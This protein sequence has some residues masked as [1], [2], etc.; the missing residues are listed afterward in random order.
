MESPEPIAIV[1]AA[2]RLPGGV[3]D[4]ASLWQ[5]LSRG[6]DAIGE[7]P[8]DRWNAARFYHP[9]AAAP[10]RMVSRWGG[11]VSN[12]DQFD[13]AFFGIAPREASHMDPQHRWLAEVAWEAIEDAGLPP[14]RLA[15]SRT[16]V[17]V[18]ISSTDFPMLHNRDPRA[19]DGYSNIGST[20]SIAANRLSYLFNF[21]GPSLSVDTACSSSLVALHLATG[22]IWSGE[23]DH[24]IVGGANALLSPESSISFSQAHMLSPRGRCRAFD[25]T[26]DGY[27][28]AEG[29]AA[30]LL[31]PLRIAQKLGLYPRALIIA[32]AS[33]QD[34]HSS[35]LTVPNQQAQEE[36]LREAL[37]RAGAEPHDVVYVEAHGTGTPVGDPIEAH[38]LAEVFGTNRA[39]NDPLFIGSVKTNVGHLESASGLAGLLKAVLV[40]EQ[41]SI[42]PNLHFET[43][44]PLLP[45]DKI[46]VPTALTPL[47]NG[48]GRGP[49][50]AV[51]SFGFGGANAHALLAAA[52]DHTSVPHDKPRDD[53]PCLFPLSARSPGA[54]ADYAEAYAAMLPDEETAPAFT[55][56]EFSA[57]AALGKSHHP[58]R[59]SLVAD[60]LAHLRTQLLQV[61]QSASQPAPAAARPKIAFVFCGQGP[62]WWAMGRQLYERDPIVREMWERCDAV[63][64]KLGGPKLLEALLATEEDSPFARTDFTQ[65]ALFAL[66]AGLVERWRAWGIEA[67]AN[68]G[69]SVGEAAAAWASGIFD[70]E[71]IFHVILTRSHWQAK[72]HG[73]GRMLAAGVSA[74]EAEP[75]VQRFAGRVSIAA[76]NAPRQ[77]T[78]SGETDALEEI[79]AALE[80]EGKFQRFLPTA[81]AFHSAQ[82]DPIESG[83]RD[84]LAGI[85]GHA[86]RVPMISTML[87]QSVRGSE[88]DAEYWWRNVRQP[89]RFAAGIERLLRDEGCT[90]FVE[91]GPHPVMA[92]ALAEITLAQKSSAVSVA[93]LRRGDD[94]TATLLQNLGLL[95]RRGAP[96]RWDALYEQPA[97]PL[98]LPAYPWQRQRLWHESAD[99]ARLLRSAP[100]H[101]LLGD[102]Q[103]LPQ[104]TWLN[105]L[106]TRLLPWLA[107]HR[108]AG[109]A[110]LPGT[111]YL[112][113]AAAAVR[114]HL[115]EPTILLEDIRFHRMLFLPPEQPVPTCVRLDPTA[116]TFQI[117]AAPPDSPAMWEVHAEG[118]YRPGRLRAPAPVDLPAIQHALKEERAPEDLYRKLRDIGQVLGPI[119][120][121]LTSL[122]VAEDE[123]LGRVESHGERTPDDYLSYPPFLDSCFQE[124]ATLEHNLAKDSRGVV[125]TVRQ[126]QLFQPLPLEAFSHLRITKRGQRFFTADVNIY[127]ASGAV[128]A[129]VDGLGV[130]AID[131]LSVQ[132]KSERKFH[133]LAWEEA[134]LVAAPERLTAPVLIFA[135]AQGFG[136]ELED[137]LRA[138]GISVTLVFAQ[139]K[140]HGRNGN[141]L[142]VDLRRADW[143][144]RLWEDLA[145]R[146]PV[147]TR[148]IDLW[149][150]EQDRGCAA[151]LAIA[152]ARLASDERD[153]AARWL[154]VTR[155]AQSVHENEK[156]NPMLAPLWGFTRTIQT[157]H[158]H[159]RVSL[160]DR[161]EEPAA[162]A[163][164]CELEAAE[165]EPEVALRDGVRWVRRLRRVEAKSAPTSTP[166][167]AYA[168]RIGQLGR[169]DS[170]EYRGRAR[171]APGRG[172]VEVEIAAAGLNFRDLMKV[173]GIYPLKDDEPT[174]LG[175]EFGGRI[176]RV[177]SGVKKFKPGDRVMGSARSE[178]AFGSHL[179][180]P[181]DYVWHLPAH[182][183][184][185]EGA[186]IPVV[187]GT[188]YHAL[189]TLARL[190]RGETILIHAAA[191]GVGLAAVQLAHQIGATVLAT[192]GNDEKR[193]LLRSMG[194]AHVM[195]SRT[196][197][198]AD[199]TLRFTEGRG[200]DVVLN[201]LAG[202][203]QQKSLAICAPHG[204][205]VEIGKRDLFENR[206]L[207]LAAFQRSLAFFAFDLPSVMSSRSAEKRALLRFLGSGF[208]RGELQPLPL[209]KFA[210]SDAVAALRFMQ[211]AQHIGKIV[212]EFDRAQ[213]P[214]VTPEFWPRPDATYLITG[215]LNGFG[216]ATARWLADRGALHLALLSRRGAPSPA[217][218]MALE[219][220]RARGVQVIALATDV[221]DKKA[222]A[223]ALRH[224]KKN[225]PPLRG[226][227]HAA[228]VLRDATIAQMTPDDLAQV[229][230]PKVTGAW[231]LHE[232]T[233]ALPLDCFFL[234]SSVSAIFG[235]AGQGNYAAANAFLDALAHHRRALGLPA[236]SVNWGQIS[237]VG[238]I[239]QRPEIGRY[240]ETI[241]L[242]GLTSQEAL[243]ALPRLLASAEAQVG[244]LE[245]DWEKLGRTSEKFK[246]S[247]IFR[248]LAQAGS[249]L[250]L[251]DHAASEW[252]GTVL[253]L[254]PEEQLAAVSDLIATQLAATLGMSAEEIDRARPL[255][256]LGMD[257]LMAVE[258]KSRIE[259]QAGSELPFNLFSADLTADRLAARF[260]KQMN[261]GTPA[262]KAAAPVRVAS[263]ED[264]PALL[265]VETRSLEELI[266][267]GDLPPLA[268]AALMP[269]PAILLEQIDLAPA[270]FFQF[271]NGGRVSLH[272]IAET[273]LGS[274][275]IFMLPL[276]AA[277][278]TPGEPTLLPR[279]L[280]GITQA[281]AC[282]AKCVALTGLIPSA[283]RYGAA[284]H[285]ALASRTELAPATTG[286]A[287][288]IAAVIL[289]LEELVRVAGRAL[290][291]E[292][293]MFYGLGSIGLGALELMLDVL[294]HP[295]A[296]RLCD[297]YRSIKFFAELEETLRGVHGY[298]GEI[299]VVRP[300]A[301][302]ESYDATVIVGATNVENVI[303]IS[304][305]APGTLVVDDSWPHCLN[306]PAALARFNS[307]QDILL[308]EGGFVRSATQMLRTAHLPA[309]LADALPGELPNLL[310]SS[311]NPNDLTACI[312]SALISAHRPELGPTVGLVNLATIRQ[313]WAALPELGFAAAELSYEGTALAPEKVRAFRARFGRQRAIA[314]K[315]AVAT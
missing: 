165:I 202:A 115:G 211:S 39:P 232:Q 149:N 51:N 108:L 177:G 289:N 272:L 172:E 195:D 298:A 75:L 168:M 304:R 129:R 243:A 96:V 70:L 171:S 66:Q 188:V 273:T 30:L 151:L 27:V 88:L 169:V 230:A 194:V 166:P 207:P 158:P 93:S 4:L 241:G 302:T 213:P 41:R 99:A 59:H 46:T 199:E 315:L 148:I 270:E 238:I 170:I 116:G 45:L 186:S 203:F 206:G 281:T 307:E 275:G 225:A 98:R 258:L 176:L 80:A 135:D 247:P 286:H 183:S 182:L 79:A 216:L 33:N 130:H 67:D 179:V 17:F 71:E 167:P 305:L 18:G 187:F 3:Q 104:P 185:A 285:E 157:E 77:V 291:E 161:A 127:D 265:R 218:A 309:A 25:A 68:L 173:L 131:A 279:L 57:A 31:M 103:P 221:A 240:L 62:Q 14:E 190:K 52:P 118:V 292:T 13:A 150:W 40:L 222:L 299:E 146:G 74:E 263:T 294:P 212:I 214:E 90:L 314:P 303:E 124:I 226:V 134:P 22:S 50:V 254:A 94:E 23:I 86:A 89:V 144:A 152:Q 47:P 274:V 155:R 141:A 252:R 82:M 121:G 34:G 24:A 267:A 85:T 147:P 117:L 107:D 138:Q 228:T 204:R 259:S 269:W 277:Q 235:A 11:F 246:T 137:L 9:N 16:G 312:L 192:A 283:T 12:T 95:Y 32:T 87:G 244:V 128:L 229:L 160:I 248:D 239:A 109:S 249:E 181:T 133:Q 251:G 8:A 227:F 69:H 65:P 114:E 156:I 253:R 38:A 136:V 72:M 261:T 35:S 56:R 280:E 2:C 122:H 29:A 278:V 209:T 140:P 208:Q 28:R 256:E 210:A 76:F 234:F 100:A 191:G 36:M 276:A 15:A 126:F 92:A 237:D 260:L 200:V 139:T 113:M 215:G 180:L 102:R 295:A 153:D 145:Q 306:G 308:T 164:L 242:R 112:E 1:G 110:V 73:R 10:G 219:E 163:I 42:P 297:P 193:D 282:G 49:L 54:L 26:A 189:H 125:S 5:L 7:V 120:Q 178:G 223:A 81:Y 290:P 301:E 53:G 6:V 288:T 58:L 198:F 97:R 184:F 310:F 236:L 162:A 196:L 233:R 55:L 217:D 61:R 19:I 154:V 91:I 60:S 123:V 20:L 37:Q 284:V 111:A 287:T 201:S 268:A 119:F 245:I 84:A 101:P 175:G 143:A 250:Q 293:V 48:N 197:D 255:T 224:L 44:N 296:L 159:W 142:T 313:H 78:L 63:C 43:P 205:F 105:H 83:M 132:E 311:L 262:P 271:L 174:V 220:L 106:D 231:N 21:R 257:S 264:A 64:Q 266:R 300:G